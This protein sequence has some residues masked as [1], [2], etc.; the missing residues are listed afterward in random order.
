MNIKLFVSKQGR[1]ILTCDTYFKDPIESVIFDYLTRKVSLKFA[2]TLSPYVLNCVVED[3][4]AEAM[5]A[6]NTC[7]FGFEKDGRIERAIFLPLHVANREEAV[8]EE[9]AAS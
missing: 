8:R 5:V 4:V 6:K 1:I 2:G 9:S 3:E 7:G